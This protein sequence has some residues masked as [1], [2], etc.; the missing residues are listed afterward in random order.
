MNQVAPPPVSYCAA[1]Y[2]SWSRLIYFGR[3]FQGLIGRFTHYSLFIADEFLNVFGVFSKV[4]KGRHKKV[5]ASF[6]SDVLQLLR[7]HL[8]TYPNGTHFD[9]IRLGHHKNE[10]GQTN[11]WKNEQTSE[12]AKKWTN[13][14]KNDQ[15]ISQSISELM[16]NEEMKCSGNQSI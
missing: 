1:M 5:I 4:F 16:R 7:V 12:W 2:C 3:T 8:V 13:E 9:T 10:K 11:E 14:Q 15:W 6:S